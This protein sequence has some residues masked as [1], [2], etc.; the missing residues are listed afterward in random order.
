M[1]P[2]DW[3]SRLAH[4]ENWYV[5]TATRT[6]HVG[7]RERLLIVG[8][9][10]P[11]SGVKVLGGRTGKTLADLL[12]FRDRE[13]L[14]ENVDALNLLPRWPG[15]AT[16]SSKGDLFPLRRAKGEAFRLRFDTGGVILLGRV[17]KAFGFN[18]V[19]PLTV[20]MLHVVGQR[21]ILLPHP[22]GVNLWW[23]DRDNVE[24]ARRAL[25]PWAT[26]ARTGSWK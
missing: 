21:V 7:S 8:E 6:A 18:K 3:Q 9:A 2:V 20:G 13:E 5:V 22:S 19:A 25:K 12:G 15:K 23:E 14:L 10:P 4:V 1:K 17:G 16:K 11:R 26:F 24:E